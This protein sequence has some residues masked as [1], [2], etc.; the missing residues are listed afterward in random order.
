MWEWFHSWKVLWLGCVHIGF[1]GLIL[2]DGVVG[3][4]HICMV[5]WFGGFIFEWCQG[6]VVWY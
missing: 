6:K 3:W 4:L 1:G 5:S 2:D